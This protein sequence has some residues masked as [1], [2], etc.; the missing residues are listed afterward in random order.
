MLLV[1][2]VGGTKIDLAVYSADGGPRAP[3]TEASYPSGRYSGLAEVVRAFLKD[4]RLTI[5]RAC[6]AVAG[7]VQDGRVSLTNLPWVIE[8][9]ALTRELGIGEVRLL[10][11]LEAMAWAV[12][13]LLPEDVHVIN[14]G[15]PARGGTIAVI[16]PGTGLGEAFLTWDGQRYRAHASE[17]GHTDFGPTGPVQTGLLEHLQQKYGHV[18]V[19]RVCSG[20]GIPEIY[21]YLR[22]SGPAAEAPDLAR[23]LAKAADQTPPI[24]TAAFNPT[25]PDPLAAATL[26]TFAAIL[27]AEAGNLALKVLATGG[28]YLA[29]GLPLRVLPALEDGRFLQAF[30]DK[31]RL[32]EVLQRIPVSVIVQRAALIGAASFGLD[33]AQ[34]SA[35][36]TT[37]R[38][39]GG[40]VAPRSRR[41]RRTAP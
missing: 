23:Q 40:A 32:G 19:E 2:D 34:T 9:S 24:I 12:P 1:G 6:F 17:G 5:S 15:E 29:G 18:S 3:L 10:N 26:A 41:R 13:S 37:S 35:D 31:G 16:A 4:R 25:G 36:A 30:R 27:G 21:T 38:R 28:V 20:I 39:Q 8:E 14:P 11:D 7:P 22:D 33:D